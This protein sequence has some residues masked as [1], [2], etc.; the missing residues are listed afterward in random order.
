MIDDF[1][2]LCREADFHLEVAVVIANF[3]VIDCGDIFAISIGH[4]VPNTL[5]F[6]FVV[7]SH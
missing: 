5:L 7:V 4:L 6:M 3:F 2:P 1:L